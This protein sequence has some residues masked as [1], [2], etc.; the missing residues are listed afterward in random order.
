[1]NSPGVHV[2]SATN[3]HSAEVMGQPRGLFTLFFTEMWE[4]FSY[5]G[6]RALL[7]LFLVDAVEH[8]GFGLSDRMAAA[9]YGLYASGVYLVALPGGWIADRL[10]S[11]QRAVWWGGIAIMIGHGMLALAPGSAFFYLG[12]VTIVAGTGLLKP[13][14]AAIVAELYPA[15][16]GRRDSGYTIFYFGINLGGFLGP[17]ATAFLARQYGWHAGFAA[18]A[19]GMAFGLA[20]FKISRHHLQNAGAKP[21]DNNQDPEMRARYTQALFV[22]LALI[23][24]AIALIYA[25][26]IPF[27]PIYIAQR[28]AILIAAMAAL[29]FTYML[30]FA[31]L[32]SVERGRILVV[33]ALFVAS[34]IFWAGFEQTGS[35]L[36]LFAD[37][38]TNLHLESIK[39]DMPAAWLQSINSLFI[40][41]CAPLFAAL[42]LAL[43][44][45]NLDPSASVKLA[46]G[47]LLVGAGFV[48]MAGAAHY[49]VQG[50]KVLPT[51]LMATYLLHTFGELAL[52]PIGMSAVTKLAP[53]RFVGQMMGIW[54]LSL[55]LGNLLAGLIAGEFSAENISAMPGQFM[56]IVWFVCIPGVVLLL[57]AKPLKKFAAGVS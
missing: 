53:Q 37:R 11:G 3:G 31:G 23:A 42:W 15:G 8:G 46:L 16:G 17:L 45:R 13:N 25:G 5:Y 20:Q 21:N 51:W 28:T 57:L 56:N 27:H 36:N 49:V 41:I 26:V 4:R 54:Y 48:V 29:F 19:L 55:S 32:T 12:L 30:F 43:A 6:M 10:L 1:M 24:A 34:S 22:V 47:L 18:A 14:I 35:S 40:L 50:Q 38:Y 39:F 44:K 7:I 9:I 33:L 2:N 52:S